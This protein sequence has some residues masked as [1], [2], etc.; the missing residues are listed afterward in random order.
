VEEGILSKAQYKKGLD[1]KIIQAGMFN[2]NASDTERQKKLEELIRHNDVD[3]EAED[4]DEEKESEVP[5]D[6]QLNILL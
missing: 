2:D 6:Y 4:D 1:D 3:D 5:N